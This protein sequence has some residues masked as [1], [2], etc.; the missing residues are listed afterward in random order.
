MKITRIKLNNTIIKLF[1]GLIN[2]K[3]SFF[4]ALILRFAIKERRSDGK[5]TF[6]YTSSKDKI[7]ILALDSQRYRGDLSAL[8]SHKKYR[9]LHI[10]QGWE[11]LLIEQ[12]FNKEMPVADIINAR[13]GSYLHDLNLRALSLLTSILTYLYKIIKVDIVTTVNYHYLPDY[14]WTLASEKIGIPWVML[15]RECNLGA[16]RF[17]DGV[18]HRH[19]L[20]HKFKGSHIIVHNKVC[21]DTFVRSGYASNN[22]IS[23]CGALRMDNYLKLINNYERRINKRKKFTLF[24]FPYNMT[25]F[26]RTGTPISNKYA[27]AYN[28]WDGRKDLFRD[29]HLSIINLALN[30]PDIDFIIKPKDIMVNTHSWEFYESVVKES[31]VDISKLDN[32]YV[33]PNANVHDLILNSDIICGLQSSTI[34]ESSIAKKRIIFP[35]FNRYEETKNFNDFLYKDY[36]HLFDVAYDKNSFKKLFKDCI[37]NPSISKECTEKRYNLFDKFFNSHEGDSLH[38]YDEVIRNIVKH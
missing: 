20:H 33:Q 29:L 32:Y 37:K 8:S 30:N 6:L 22:Q 2:E 12:F 18:E 35:I 31:N 3:T 27:Y 14:H 7:T 24:Y 11:R 10:S 4:V 38:K 17:V 34:I 36:L 23:I 26:G 5:N 21:K 19:K 13:P 28:I 25:L 16:E 9:V 1:I 15:Y